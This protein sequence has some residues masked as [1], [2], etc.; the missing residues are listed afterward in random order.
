MGRVLV[1]IVEGYGDEKAVPLLIRRILHERL[2][3]FTV[4]VARPFRVPRDKV[5]KEYELERAIIQAQR[6]QKDAGAI[7]VLLDTDPDDCPVVTASLLLEKAKSAT[8]LPVAVVLAQLEY[9]CWFLGAKKFL[10]GKCGIRYDAESVPHAETIRGA[11]GRLERNMAEGINYKET[12]DQVKL[13]AK[14]DLDECEKNC[15]S[16]GKLL[17]DV[18]SLID[19]MTRG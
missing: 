7:L 12:R 14:L 9:E 6:K 11:K 4:Q 1:P 10:R 8:G 18:Q 19:R 17:R 2:Q 5:V 13:T 15:Q 16:F 3:E